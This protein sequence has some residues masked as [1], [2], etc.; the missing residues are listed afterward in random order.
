M[1]RALRWTVLL[2][3]LVPAPA[4]AQQ[5]GPTRTASVTY[6]GRDWL[7]ID[8]GWAQGL[9]RGAEVEIVRRR[10]T[11]AVLRVESVGDHQASCV[12]VSR[13][14]PLMLGDSVRFTPVASPTRT[15]L[16]VAARPPPPP[17]PPV[18]P[19]PRDSTTPAP[20]TA[21]AL[22]QPAV[23]QPAVQTPPRTDSSAEDRAQQPTRGI[24]ASRQSN[25][26][27]TT[28]VTFVSGAEIY[29]DAGRQEGL[30]EGSELVVVRR[31]SLVSTLRVKFVASHQ[32]SCEVIRGAKDIVVGDVVRFVPRAPAAA[33]GTIATA[34][35]RRGPRRLSGPGIHGRLGMR[36]LRAT[37]TTDSSGNVTGSTGFHQPSFDLRLSGLSIGGTPIGLSVDLRTR[38]TVTSSTG[39]PNS[40]DGKTRVYQAA[41]FWGGPGAG[42]RTVAGRQYLTAVTSVSM[43]DGGLIEFNGSRV[44]LGAF[45]G[46]EPDA[47]SLGFS[48]EIQ[49]YGGYL[50]FHNPPG[51]AASW[52]FTTGA[53]G[54]YEASQANREFG[55]MQVSVNNSYFSFYGLQEVD[56]YPSWKVQLG[57]KQFSFT[58]QYASGLL[59]PSRWLSF[60]GSY[61]NRRSVRLYRDTQNPE[62]TFDDSYRQGYGGGIQLSSH[63]IRVGGDWRR[64][65]GGTAGSADSYTG[66]FGLDGF[67]PL[68]VGVSA[69]A[70]WYQ[71]QNDSTLNNPGARRTSGRLYSG[72]LGFDPVGPLHIDFNGGVRREDNPNTTTMQQSTWYGVDVDASVARSWFVS[73]SGL[74]Q[75]DP[76]NPGTSVTT[77][78]YG[79]ITW[80]F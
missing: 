23:A 18:A 51:T 49:D 46:L 77:Q 4:V 30:I 69:R 63:K 34:T 43:F 40:V 35:R 1:A 76:A 24:T 59:R 39:Q 53:V 80:R 13:Q 52:S 71:N 11:V 5:V 61:D 70:T 32:S 79:S 74:R 16:V 12:V 64:S 65:T 2:G 58:S 68:K 28:T 29:V 21:P 48:R 55:F 75:E 62:T 60:S 72:R 26:A 78:L 6:L 36:Y 47:V 45:G 7:F 33:T 37:S 57:E 14:L 25:T 15:P 22:A 42:F 73:F 38:R 67:T 10:R 19:P 17:V 56:R 44:T 50:Q 66:T 9:R 3:L 27:A 31:D 41:I 54:S 20:V 8:A